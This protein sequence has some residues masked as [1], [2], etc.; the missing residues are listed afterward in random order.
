M[1]RSRI[2]NA[3]SVFAA[4]SVALVP[5]ALAAERPVVKVP[6]SGAKYTGVS[7]DRQKVSLFPSGKAVQIV[8]FDFVCV[9]KVVGSTSLEAIKLTRTDNG[10]RFS[11]RAHGI[12]SYKDGKP[13]ENAAISLSGRFSRSAKSVTGR[14]RVRSPR[15]RSTSFHDWHAAKRQRA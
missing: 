8:A 10:Y 4:T 11:I 9:G 5:G 3:V 2:V 13:D 14:L 1:T 12:V 6:S 15:C 7:D